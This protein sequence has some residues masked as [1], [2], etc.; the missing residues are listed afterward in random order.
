MLL[1]VYKIVFF[2]GGDWGGGNIY[3]NFI[4]ISRRKYPHILCEIYTLFFWFNFIIVFVAFLFI[5][6]KSGN[7]EQV[8]FFKSS[9]S[10][11]KR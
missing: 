6:K 1:F 4:L 5:K 3:E 11:I 2:W 10:L 7:N 8:C 9:Y